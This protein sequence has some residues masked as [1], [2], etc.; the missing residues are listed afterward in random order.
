[1]SIDITSFSASILPIQFLIHRYYGG[2]KSY[3]AEYLKIE[4]TDH[5]EISGIV[6]S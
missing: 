5:S 1:M 3:I 2:V 4:K 6:G